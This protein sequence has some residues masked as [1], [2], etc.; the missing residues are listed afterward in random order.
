MTLQQEFSGKVFLQKYLESSTHKAEISFSLMNPG[1]IIL[2]YT[3]TMIL[4]FSFQLFQHFRVAWEHIFRECHSAWFQTERNSVFCPAALAIWYC[5]LDF[6]Q[7]VNEPAFVGLENRFRF[8]GCSCRCC[9]QLFE[10]PLK[11]VRQIFVQ[12]HSRMY[13]HRVMKKVQKAEFGIIF[14]PGPL[15][16]ENL[17]LTELPWARGFLSYW[18]ILVCVITSKWMWKCWPTCH[19]HLSIPKCCGRL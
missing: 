7:K 15:W 17:N 11:I 3:A 1:C 9:V 13:L 14:W 4:Y 6:F 16:A 10:F 18:V 2:E 8:L 19:R 12:P 5:V